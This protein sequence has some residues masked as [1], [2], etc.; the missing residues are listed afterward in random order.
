L[1]D[2]TTRIAV[3][4]QFCSWSAWRMNRTSIARSSVGWTSYSPIFHIMLRKLAG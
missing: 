2:A 3:V 4:P 1:L